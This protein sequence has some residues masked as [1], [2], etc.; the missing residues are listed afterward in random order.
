[1][2]VKLQNAYVETLL[3]NFI[4]VVKQNIMLQAQL[5]VS[6]SI[7]AENADIRNNFMEVTKRNN[8][9]QEI[10]NSLSGENSNLKNSVAQKDVLAEKDRLQTA[11]NGYMKQVKFFE[12]R[13]EKALDNNSQLTKYI[14]SLEQLV[15]VTKLKKIKNVSVET[16]DEDIKNGGSF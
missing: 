13:L 8:E 7:N 16:V 15:P 14:E 9:L 11:V 5:E 12:D 10:V 4:A 6:N 2:D 1:M 3:E